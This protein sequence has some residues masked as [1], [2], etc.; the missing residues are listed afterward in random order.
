MARIDVHVAFMILAR[1]PG[2]KAVTFHTRVC[3]LSMP[4]EPARVGTHR[5]G[6]SGDQERL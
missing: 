3:V 6:P 2:L 1:D 5:G 4:E